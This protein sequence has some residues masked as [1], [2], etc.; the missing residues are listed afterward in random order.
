MTDLKTLNDLECQ[1]CAFSDCDN[2]EH[3]KVDLFKLD[4]QAASVE[5]LRAEAIKWI[6]QGS[7]DAEFI[8][9]AEAVKQWIK[10]FFN[11]TEEDLK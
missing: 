7:M 4:G 11:L 3:H 9:E 8:N 1:C 10:H 5:E 2:D 6:K